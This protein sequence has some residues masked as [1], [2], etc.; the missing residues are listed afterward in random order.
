MDDYSVASSRA[1]LNRVQLTLDD[2]SENGKFDTGNSVE[3]EHLFDFDPTKNSS[4]YKNELIKLLQKSRG[5]PYEKTLKKFV[6][7]K[8]KEINFDQ[9][10]RQRDESFEG[11]SVG[12]SQASNKRPSLLSYSKSIFD[13]PNHLRNNS[14]NK[15][16]EEELTKIRMEELSKPLE[17]N[18]YRGPQDHRITTNHLGRQRPPPKI[19]IDAKKIHLG[20]ETRISHR[21]HL[22]PSSPLRRS[23]ELLQPSTERTIVSM[24]EFRDWLRNNRQWERSSKIKVKKLFINSFKTTNI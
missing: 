9:Q 11:Q 21:G 10:Q 23:E 13:T 15:Y 6:E 22:S 7:S 8:L 3:S 2:L 14:Y 18:V 17:R 24:D 16:S 4:T 5:T 12:G 1:S 19:I 20:E